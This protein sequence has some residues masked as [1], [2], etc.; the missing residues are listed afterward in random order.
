MNEPL[1]RRNLLAVPST[2]DPLPEE[3]IAAVATRNGFSAAASPSA[4]S[5][6]ESGV[7][8]RKRQPMGRD[9]QFNVRLR[10]ETLDFIY[11]QANGRN[12]PHMGCF[13]SSSFFASAAGVSPAKRGEAQRSRERSDLDA[14]AAEHT[15]ASERAL[16]RSCRPVRSL[17]RFFILTLHISFCVSD[18]K[19]EP[20]FRMQPCRPH[21]LTSGRALS[22]RTIIPRARGRRARVGG[23]CL[24]A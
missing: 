17:P 3:A 23:F 20:V 19:R 13:R 16:A 2:P 6:T 1:K 15:V 14:P 10:H 4:P 21:H 22:A 12:I 8:R 9:H 24:T 18:P 11:G 5:S 7:S